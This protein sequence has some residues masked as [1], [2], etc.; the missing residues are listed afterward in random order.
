MP[1][2][3]TMPGLLVAF[4]IVATTVRA[5][6]IEVPADQPTIAAAIEAARAGD[7]VRV[8][9]GVYR[10]TIVMKDGVSIVGA[11]SDK[12]T[13]NGSGRGP[14]VI[15]ENVGPSGRLE[16][17]TITGG[18]AERGGG[19]LNVRSSPVITSCIFRGNSA[20]LYGLPEAAA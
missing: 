13:I 18:S 14:V 6:T 2:R 12:T 5:G 15:A 1:H 10:E 11:G 4:A 19:M 20:A 8:A 17:F 9:P 16:G 7:I 3:P